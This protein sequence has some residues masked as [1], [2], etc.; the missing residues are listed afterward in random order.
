MTKLKSTKPKPRILMMAGGTGGHVFPA[1][2]VARYLQARDWEV[3]WLASQ[4]GMETEI[5]SKAEIPLH[6]IDIKGV[7]RNGLVAFLSAPFQ[8]ARAIMQSLR[9][10]YK[11]KPQVVL[12][13]G[14]FVAGPGG[15]AAWLLRRPL[16]IH[17]QNAIAGVTN[18]WLAKVATTV[19]E[20]FPEA[21]SSQLKPIYTGNPVREAL[22]AL[23]TPVDRFR[24]RT[25]SV[26]LL[27]L[28]GSRGAKVLNEICP[29]ALGKIRLDKRPEVWHQTG[30]GHTETTRAIYQKYG[31]VARIEPFIEE[32]SEAYAWAD[33]VVCRAGALTIAELAAV[34]IG[35]IL[36]PFPFAVDDHQAANAQY[37]AKEKAAIVIPQSTLTAEKLSE[38]LSEYLNDK[39]QLLAMANAAYT[40]AKRDAL[41]EVS[42]YCEELNDAS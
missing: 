11:L 23:P 42:Y 34:G 14:G 38:I 18:R 28:G 39:L 13:M 3:H 41:M 20:G 24:Q 27:I 6:I 30:E 10:V 35:S 22:L 37:L 17:E 21:F 15:I 4:G 19:L 31:V 36:V 16:V 8:I 2:A 5:V 9:I 25:G 26:R 7:R 33:L 40:A 1:L 29:E 12:G 32:M